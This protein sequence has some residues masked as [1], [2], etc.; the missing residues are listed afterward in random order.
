MRHIL[1]TSGAIV[2]LAAGVVGLTAGPAAAESCPSGA[3][4]AYT[5]T[6]WASSAGPVTG[7]N[8]NLTGYSRWTGAESIYNNGKSCNVYI[9]SATGYNGSRYPLNKGTGWRTISGSAIW[10]HAYSNQ[11]Y[12]C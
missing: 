5:T 10:H 8:K 2:T 1:A 7:N 9:Y 11:W 12:G 4:C 3:T 6:N